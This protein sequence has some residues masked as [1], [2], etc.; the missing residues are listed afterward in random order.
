MRRRD[1]NESGGV[2]SALERRRPLLIATT[3]SLALHAALIVVATGPPPRRPAAI[4]VSLLPGGA[5]GGRGSGQA[6][7]ATGAPSEELTSV[8]VPV[9]APE[10]R[11]RAAAVTTRAAATAAV[12]EAQGPAVAAAGS[13]DQ[14]RGIAG[15]GG[16]EGSVAGAGWGSGYGVGDGA[17]L[18]PRALCLYCPEPS[19]PLVARARGWQGSVEVALSVLADGSVDRASLGR[20]SGY[21]ALDAAAI[22]VARQSRFRLPSAVGSGAPLQGRI[23]YRF[24]LRGS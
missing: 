9:A 18:D 17:G 20:S 2:G 12:A 19:Y 8:S 21:P 6:V 15:A 24:V 23:E 14:A 3:V 4:A 7:P 5:P 22:A 1:A 10:P 13:D 11:R 16:H